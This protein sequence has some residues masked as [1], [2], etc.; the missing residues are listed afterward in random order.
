[1]AGHE[2]AAVRHTFP[3]TDE[4]ACR[5]ICGLE[6]ELR[7]REEA[8]AAAPEHSTWVVDRR[9]NILAVAAADSFQ[10]RRSAQEE[11]EERLLPSLEEGERANAWVLPWA[12]AEVHDCN[13]LG[14][15]EGGGL[16]G[17]V[18]DEDRVARRSVPVE[19]VVALAMT[20]S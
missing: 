7:P 8:A 15:V 5:D 9:G 17:V 6:S 1:M 13:A 18:T 12:G 11:E 2:T 19:V 10:L 16:N 14:G 3:A 4:H 20:S